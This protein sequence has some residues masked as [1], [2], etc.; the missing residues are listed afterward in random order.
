MRDTQRVQP[1]QCGKSLNPFDT[2]V[3]EVEY[4]QQL[5]IVKSLNALDDVIV[6]IERHQLP[7]VLQVFDGGDGVIVQ[8]DCFQLGETVQVLNLV[9]AFEVQVQLVVE[10]GSGVEAFCFCTPLQILKRHD[11]VP[12]GVLFELCRLLFHIMLHYSARQ[13]HIIVYAL[14]SLLLQVQQVCLAMQS[15]GVSCEIALRV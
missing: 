2:V 1:L 4:R 11:D 7:T 6:E 9:K 12:V 8:P 3:G 14:L 15:T 5:Q 13:S 10:F